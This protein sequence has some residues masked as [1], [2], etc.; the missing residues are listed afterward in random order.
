MTDLEKYYKKEFALE[1]GMLAFK[2]LPDDTIKRLEKSIGFRF[3]QLNIAVKNMGEAL[4]KSTGKT[5]IL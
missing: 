3:Y 1:S 2:D 5:G 4:W